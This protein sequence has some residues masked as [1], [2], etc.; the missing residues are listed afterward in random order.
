MTLLDPDY[1]WKYRILGYNNMG[2][3]VE[4]LLCDEEQIDASHDELMSVTGVTTVTTVGPLRVRKK[5]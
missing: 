2:G 1:V 5:Q 3:I 4:S